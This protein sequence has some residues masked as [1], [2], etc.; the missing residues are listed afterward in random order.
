[1]PRGN[2]EEIT[3]V[4]EQVIVTIVLISVLF[5]YNCLYVFILRVIITRNYLSIEG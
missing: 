2:N 5:I 4:K 3:S 1:M